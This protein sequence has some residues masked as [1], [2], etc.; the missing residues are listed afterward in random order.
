MDEKKA[1]IVR[2][3][4]NIFLDLENSSAKSFVLGYYS[5]SLAVVVQSFTLS[6]CFFLLMVSIT[7][8]SLCT[9]HL[10]LL[11]ITIYSCAMCRSGSG[12]R[13]FLDPNTDQDLVFNYCLHI[14]VYIFISL[15]SAINFF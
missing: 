4:N 7:M 15:K 12:S 13:L 10:R 11:K 1:P 6:T 5:F 9:I 14:C 8:A 2:P 3:R